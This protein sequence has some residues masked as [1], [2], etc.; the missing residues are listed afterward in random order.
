MNENEREKLRMAYL[1]GELSS[2]ETA[3]FDESLTPEEHARMA[4]EVRLEA[5][6]AEALKEEAGCPDAVWRRTQLLVRNSAPRTQRALRKSWRMAVAAVAAMLLMA[7]VF[8]GGADFEPKPVFAITTGSLEEFKATSKVAPEHGAVQAYFKAHD[9]DLGLVPISETSPAKNG[10]KTALVGAICIECKGGALLE[11][12]VVCCGH[13]VKVVVAE[14]GT[15]TARLMLQAEARG[16]VQ[17]TVRIGAYRAGVIS[18][19]HPAHAFVQLL[20][21]GRESSV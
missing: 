18:G 14:E 5:G 8:S 17:H 20:R 12:L 15:A 16:E 13:P 11:V 19:A 4:N 6:L 3:A 7:F 2:K 9:I 21:A 1:D 10:H